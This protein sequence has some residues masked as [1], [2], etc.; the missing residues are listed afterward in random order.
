MAT[1]DK[2]IMTD[3][4]GKDIVSELRKI[5][6]AMA[7]VPI[8]K[9]GTG[10]TTAREILEVIGAEPKHNV[11]LEEMLQKTVKSVNGVLPDEN[12]DL[13]LLRVPSAEN[14]VSEE[15]Q[16]ID[17]LFV[18]RTTGGTA[19]VS[20]GP[21]T[22]GAIYGNSVHEGYI[23]ESK[24]FE[25]H[26]AGRLDN[27]APITAVIDWDTY[28]SAANNVSMNK[29]FV[30]T[31]EWS[32]NPVTYGLSV[33]GTPVNGDTI[34]VFFTV[35]NRGTITNASPL[36]FVETNWNLYDGTT[37]ICRVL[38][39]SDAYGFK[40]GGTYTGITFSPTLSGIKTSVTPD[41]N[42]LFDIPEDGYLFVTGGNQTDTYI[43]MTWSDWTGG[44]TGDF[45]AASS[46]VIDLTSLMTQSFQFGLCAVGGVMDEINFGEQV[47]YSR[48][49]RSAYSEANLAAA[50]ASGQPYIY[51]ANWI[52]SVKS[53]PERIPFQIINTLTVYD[54]GTERFTGTEIPVY[55]EMLFGQNL[56]DKLR[57]DVVT[58]S[59]QNLTDSQKQ[60][61]RQN[62]GAAADA[63][64]IK[65]INHKLPD[66]Y[67]DITIIE[68]E[69]DAELGSYRLN[70]TIPVSSWTA[71]N[72]AYTVTFSDS[73]IASDM[74][75]AET[76][77]DDPTA[78][79]GNTTFTT[80]DGS[81]TITTTV[82]PTAVWNLH[83]TL[84]TN[85]AKVLSL[86][87][88]K[89]N[90]KAVAYVEDDDT[91]FHNIAAG[92]YLIWKDE[93]HRA[94]SAIAIGDTIS[95]KAVKLD[96]GGLNTLKSEIFGKVPNKVF[97]TAVV[98]EDAL[99]TM[100]TNQ[101]WM[102]AFSNANY[103]GD[104]KNLFGGVCY[105]AQFAMG[106][107]FRIQIAFSINNNR[108]YWRRRSWWTEVWNGWRMLYSDNIETGTINK[109]S[110]VTGGTL[111][112]GTCRK[113]G[114]IVTV[115]ARMW[116]ISEPTDRSFF[117]IPSGFRPATDVFGI[118]YINVTGVGSM[119]CSVHIY[120]NGN[121]E[122][123]YSSSATTNQV[124]F[125][126]TYAV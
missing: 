72:D 119:P 44:Y 124:Y 27:A 19:S 105:V 39:Y 74:D 50:E 111:A 22:I 79:L 30:Y 48:I 57:T 46:D 38:K 75:G 93:L 35:E 92:E 11:N 53:T 110:D 67:G 85:G 78:M 33:G 6:G 12:G 108:V 13:R 2:R 34:N 65:S 89:A 62:I 91:A 81:I 118:G 69:G 97:D 24:Y 18:E 58:L 4:T 5:P 56:K 73:L 14:L 107:G 112:N 125:F 51:D 113:I 21:A 28:A 17:G 95:G 25:I 7:P 117:V 90:K 8:E 98:A 66:A 37:G 126:A 61:A 106:E 83:V 36:T 86:A 87:N 23:P 121:V 20:D 123:A 9:G 60:Q 114:N 16:M 49:A 52:Y 1:A 101:N 99:D 68:G 77:L 43:L 103:T 96:D 47:A 26:L 109:A 15:S 59:S 42:G 40:I 54:H 100:P 32:E 64:V 41:S 84:I 3:K 71:S 45:A 116:G 82:K 29:T 10:V 122:Y 120:P 70:V 94:S 104:L 76:W 115:S 31:T 80:A 63:A 102:V 55:V 88:T